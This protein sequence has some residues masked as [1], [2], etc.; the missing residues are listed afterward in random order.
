MVRLVSPP[1]FQQVLS[2]TPL[3]PLP[4]DP[5]S[6]PPRPQTRMLARIMDPEQGRMLQG[7]GLRDMPPDAI[8]DI[9]V[10][11]VCAS[12]AQPVGGMQG[13]DWWDELKMCDCCGR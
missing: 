13:L 1:C 10:M 5:S 2:K 3:P 6:A 11:P 8:M 9:G 4:P 12:S 7:L